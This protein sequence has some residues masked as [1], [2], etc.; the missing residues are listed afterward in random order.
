MTVP[1]S[2][3]TEYDTRPPLDIDLAG[4]YFFLLT[5]GVEL[6]YNSG[7]EIRK[8]WRI[9]YSAGLENQ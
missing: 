6:W 3:L 4:V 8:S 9:G 5:N 2:S 7:Q 1:S